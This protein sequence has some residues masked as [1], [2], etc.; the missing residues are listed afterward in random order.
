MKRVLT[1]AG[2][3]PSGWAGVSADL[4]TFGDLGVDGAAAITALTAQNRS[5]VTAVQPVDPKF[6]RQEIL[7]LL[8]EAE[9]DAVK[10]GM[11]ASS[12]TVSM[13]IRLIKKEG[14][15]NIV[16]DPVLSSSSGRRLIDKKGERELVKLLPLVRVVTP[17]IKE[18]E[19][20]SGEKIK[21]I[22]GMERAAEKI[23]SLGCGAVVVTGGHLPGTPTDVLVDGNNGSRGA[24]IMHFKGTRLR[25]RKER[26]HGTG[27]IFSSALAAGLA[28]GYSTKKATKTA[29]EYLIQSIKAR[30]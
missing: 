28:R 29:Q 3:D 21:D 20:L 23:R 17:N 27:C 24:K 1:I 11:L 26:F 22:T 12:E 6:V 18:A 4:K 16:L 5:T 19:M 25:G 7:T 14:L 13:L 9:F 2:F 8:A 30:N 15:N 10:I